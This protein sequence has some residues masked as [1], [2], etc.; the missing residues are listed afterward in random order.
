MPDTDDIGVVLTS[1]NKRIDDVGKE[2]DAFEAFIRGDAE[3]YAPKNLIP[4]PIS[5]STGPH[6]EWQSLVTQSTNDLNA[7]GVILEHATTEALLKHLSIHQSE[8]DAEGDL[9]ALRPSDIAVGL[10]AGFAGSLTSAGLEK[11]LAK[12]HDR[13]PGMKKD[14]PI[15]WRISEYLKHEGSPMDA[16]RGRK[17]RFKH[18]HD[19][20]NPLEVWDD[21]VKQYGGNYG[22]AL[23]WVRHMVCDSLSKEGLPL[24]GHSLFS[25]RLR[26]FLVKNFRADELASYF[27]VRTRDLLGAGLVTAILFAYHR[28]RMHAEGSPR[29]QNYRSY[30][31]AML[32]HGTC[33]ISGLM[34][35]TLNYGSLVLFGKNALRATIY[36]MKISRRL[37]T[38]RQE[39]LQRVSSPTDMGP[40]LSELINGIPDMGPFPM[41]SWATFVGDVQIADNIVCED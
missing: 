27:S 41:V 24:P 11:P 34:L 19:I 37:D 30:L 35:G 3:D 6:D 36:D 5:A 16:M 25:G 21:L 15:L 31:T 22:A 2:L 33:L 8:W 17:H 32:A 12:V 10:V 20:F 38:Q 13:P 28:Y 4:A 18:G 39:L 14:N 26:D 7:R 1:I 40:P 29:H 9:E 23:H